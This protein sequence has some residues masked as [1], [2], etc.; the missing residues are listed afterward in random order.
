MRRLAEEAKIS[1]NES[2]M[3]AHHLE[4]LGIIKIQPVGRAY[5][6]ELNE[7]S[8]ILNKIIKPVFDAEQ[9]TVPQVI[10]T[11]KKYLDDKKIISS[12]LF[13][14]VVARE[15]K[16]D[17]DIDLLIISNDFD[18]AISVV[19][20][21]SMEVFEVFHGNISH[22]IFSEKEFKSKKNGDL[23]RSILSNHIL[24]CGKKLSDT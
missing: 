10:Q 20:K 24:I 19:S 14:S 23:I 6:L 18:Y 17:S 12:V 8:Y 2:A 21:A 13:G 15:E 4:K 16:I 3:T 5:Q 11:L 22:I 9:N 1:P 7:K